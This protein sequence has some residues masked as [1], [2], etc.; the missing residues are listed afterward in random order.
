MTVTTEIVSSVVDSRPDY[1]HFL[2]LHLEV[3][4]YIGRLER[5]VTNVMTIVKDQQVRVESIQRQYD[6]ARNH[7]ADDISA[8]GTALMQE[9]EERD[10]CSVYDNFV[11]DLNSRLHVELDTRVQ[12]YDI[13]LV[14]QV[15]FTGTFEASC[16]GDALELARDSFSAYS[17][18]GA[19]LD[20][21][22]YEIIDESADVS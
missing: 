5:E 1:S 6:N 13:E 21:H 3:A 18:G 17:Y 11:K 20:V 8:I 4:E 19:E 9:A 12:D 10:W 16:E 14:V 2:E 7:H 15:K 22:S